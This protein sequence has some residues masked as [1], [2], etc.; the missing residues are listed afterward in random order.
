MNQPIR[1]NKTFLRQCINYLIYSYHSIFYTC[2]KDVC[3]IVLAKSNHQVDKHYN[4]LYCE[5][6]DCL[7]QLKETVQTCQLMWTHVQTTLSLGYGDMATNYDKYNWNRFIACCILFIAY[8]CNL[9]MDICR[10]LRW[11]V[12]VIIWV[13]SKII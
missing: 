13:R 12:H 2:S 11:C 1:C 3:Q 8:Y 5:D 4:Y 9:N 6:D 10:L 7:R